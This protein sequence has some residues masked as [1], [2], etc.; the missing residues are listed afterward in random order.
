MIV[1]GVVQRRERRLEFRENRA[2]V[3]AG[4]ALLE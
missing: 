3:D 1:A 2:T 4:L